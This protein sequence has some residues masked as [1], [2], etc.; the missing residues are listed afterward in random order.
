MEKCGARRGFSQQW[1][2]IRERERQR[3]SILRAARFLPR[4]TWKERIAVKDATTSAGQ[5]DDELATLAK[6]R[7]HELELNR[8]LEE[9]RR[10]AT[11]CA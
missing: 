9:A 8:R 6:L 2:I 1:G 10:T 7:T 4:V 11:I 3:R 5:A